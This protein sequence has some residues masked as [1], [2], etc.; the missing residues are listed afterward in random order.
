MTMKVFIMARLVKVMIRTMMW[1]TAWNC[2]SAYSTVPAAERDD[3]E[4][5]LVDLQSQV[6][7]LVVRLD[8]RVG[9]PSLSWVMNGWRWEMAGFTKALQN[10]P[11]PGIHKEISGFIVTLRT[12]F[13]RTA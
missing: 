10:L 7:R 8:R 2:R 1:L 5:A 13:L 3:V 12:L 4:A 6:A 9:A 11:V